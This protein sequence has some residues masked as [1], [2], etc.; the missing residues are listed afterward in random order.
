MK[1]SSAPILIIH[2]GALGDLMMSLPALFS[3]RLFHEGIPWTIAGNP[4]TLSLL[5]HRFY[6]Q[7]IVSI[8]QKEWAW[9]FQEEKDLP[10]RFQRY[11]SSFEKVYLFSAR[12]QELMIRGLKRAGLEKVVWIPSLPDSEKGITLEILQRGVLESENIPWEKSE[13]YIFP[14]PEDKDEAGKLLGRYREE[15][16]G[17]PLWAI[18]PGSGSPHKNWP[19]ERFLETAEILRNGRQVQPIFLL[20]PVEQER[21]LI[22]NGTR[23]RGW[24]VIKEIGLPLLAGVLSLCAG[25]LGNDS[26]V[27][28]LAAA[29]GVPTVVLFGPTDPAFWGPRGSAV[30]VLSPAVPC[31]PCDRETMRSCPIKACLKDL[32]VQQVLEVIGALLSN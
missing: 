26:G 18:H 5:D 29:V 24:P 19:L 11:L 15:A 16:G 21:S 23:A 31:A 10:D 17:R 9:L 7:E 6:A 20:G 14:V 25:Y 4:E 22:L 3:L 1:T 12:Q 28:H 27:S 13:R 2:Q 8:H 30:R 32:D